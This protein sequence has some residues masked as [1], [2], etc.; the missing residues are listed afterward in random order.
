MYIT[1]T[2][3]KTKLRVMFER[4]KIPNC[5]ILVH[6]INTKN[7]QVFEVRTIERGGGGK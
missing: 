3:K 1:S 4:P 7:I 6:L 2:G 5:E